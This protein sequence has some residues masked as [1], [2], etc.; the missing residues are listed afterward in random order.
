MYDLGDK[1][2]KDIAKQQEKDAEEREELP[3]DDENAQKDTKDEEKEASK[4]EVKDKNLMM[5]ESID[6]QSR[7]CCA[8][9]SIPLAWPKLLML[10]IVEA[11]AAKVMIRH[12][13]GEHSSP[14]LPLF[15]D[16]SQ[17]TDNV[18]DDKNEN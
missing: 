8:S 13:D 5:D 10:E 15:A 4:S 17:R 1:E 7:I 16:V 11:I 12:T 9:I 18:S 2:D 14:F 3:P 6:S